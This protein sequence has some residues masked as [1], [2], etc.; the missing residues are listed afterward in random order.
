M[1]TIMERW[2]Y[3]CEHSGTDGFDE[4]RFES[5]VSFIYFWLGTEPG[6]CILPA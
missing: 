2:R 4:E 3:K 5:A 1:K 6:F